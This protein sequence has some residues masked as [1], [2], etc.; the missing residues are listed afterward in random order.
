MVASDLRSERT[1]LRPTPGDCLRGHG[2]YGLPP[3]ACA[4]ERRAFSR[5]VIARG[6]TLS[7]VGSCLL[8]ELDDKRTEEP[9]AR[10]AGDSLVAVHVGLERDGGDA[11]LPGKHP[12]LCF[13][14]A[15]G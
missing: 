14:E 2:R 15:F 1:G 10:E 5:F 8:L 12:C 7:R 13:R 6:E 3:T 9:D 4:D 11:R